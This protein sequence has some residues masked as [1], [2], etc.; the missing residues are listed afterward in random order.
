LKKEWGG[1]RKGGERERGKR[2]GRG[3]EGER[4]GESGDA[5]TDQTE[6]LSRCK[7][8]GWL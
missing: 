8:A 5:S 2:R 7:A 1:W 6:F 3:R 4:G